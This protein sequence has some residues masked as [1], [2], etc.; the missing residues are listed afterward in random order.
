MAHTFHQMQRQCA[1]VI[2]LLLILSI[3]GCAVKSAGYC[4]LSSRQHLRSTSP[5]VQFIQGKPHPLL[6]RMQKLA[7]VPTRI[8]RWRSNTADTSAPGESVEVLQDYMQENRLTDVPV[9]VNEYD[10]TGEWQRLRQ[11]DRIAPGWRYTAGVVSVASYTLIPGRV[12]GQDHYNPFTNSLSVNSDRVSGSLNA[13]AYAKDIH[14]QEHAGFYAFAGS[15]PG[16]SLFKSTRAVN[17]V[18]QYAQA[19]GHWNLEREVYR[20]QYPLVAAESVSPAGYFVSPLAGI[21]LT[22]GGGTVGYAVG[23]AAEQRRMSELESSGE[24]NDDPAGLT[25]VGYL[26]PDNEPVNAL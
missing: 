19:A 13:A 23:R 12:I 24:L 21:A 2:A 7:E 3:T 10:P 17:D 5:Q 26:H 4:G 15:L 16:L 14:A 22:M 20:G 11:N 6:D 8:I 9:L 1:V 18:L 25:L